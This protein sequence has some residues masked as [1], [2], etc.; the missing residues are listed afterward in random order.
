MRKRTKKIW[1]QRFESNTRWRSMQNW[2]AINNSIKC[3]LTMH[4]SITTSNLKG[5]KRENLAPRDLNERDIERQKI[6]C[7]ILLQRHKRKT[8]LHSI[9]TD[10]NPKWPKVWVHLGETGQKPKQ[11]NFSRKVMLFTWCYQKGVIYY[12]ILKPSN[13]ITPSAIFTRHSSIGLSFF[14]KVEIEISLSAV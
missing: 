1:R 9:V 11:N 10:D 6:M 13:T 2:N 7:E 14:H 12:E 4:F 5:S 3:S 8:F